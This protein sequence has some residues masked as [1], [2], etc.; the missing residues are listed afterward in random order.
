[1]STSSNI[2]IIIGIVL[3]PIFAAATQIG[4]FGAQRQSNASL[5]EDRKVELLFG[6]VIGRAICQGASPETSPS[7]ER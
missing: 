6:K 3:I 4:Q 2:A 7:Q 5:C 1:M